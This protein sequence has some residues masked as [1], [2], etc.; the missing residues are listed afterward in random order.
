MLKQ[1]ECVATLRTGIYGSTQQNQKEEKSN[2][3]RKQKETKKEFNER[4]KVNFQKMQDPQDTS[5]DYNK[6]TLENFAD[7]DVEKQLDV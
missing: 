7:L 5:Y 4:I 6:Y 2:K 1:D 3:K